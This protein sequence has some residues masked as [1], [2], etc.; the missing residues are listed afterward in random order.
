M[1]F[2]NFSV[3][4]IIFIIRIK[5][6]KIISIVID[7]EIVLCLLNLLKNLKNEVKLRLIR[8]KIVVIILLIDIFDNNLKKSIRDYL[9]VCL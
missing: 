9:E 3:I 6:V 8:D 5:A 7:F 1:F 4:S 2:V